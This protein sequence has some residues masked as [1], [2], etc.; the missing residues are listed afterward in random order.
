MILHYKT[1]RYLPN[2]KVQVYVNM[3]S[4]GSSG[5]IHHKPLFQSYINSVWA[6]LDVILQSNV[7]FQV[8]NL[9]SVVI[10]VVDIIST[11]QASKYDTRKKTP[12]EKSV[13]VNYW[14]I[15]L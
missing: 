7:E 11:Q 2:D 6:K 1:Y 3:I 13:D 4:K 9:S 15:C 14:H 8:T 5:R 12:I 10:S